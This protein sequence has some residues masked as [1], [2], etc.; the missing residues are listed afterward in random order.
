MKVKIGLEVHVQLNTKTKL[1]CNCPTEQ[2]EPNSSVCE[3]CL[4]M[5]GSKPIANKK[6]IEFAA[7]LA[8]ALNA[9]IQEKNY[10]SRKTYFYPDL[11]KN[12]QI[13]QYETPLAI[14]GCIEL[15]QKKISI[16]RIHLEEDPASLIHEENTAY[17]L[18]DYNRS[19]IP[20]VEIVTE[21]EIENPKQARE[22]L[23]KIT[24]ILNYLE[25]FEEGK[26]ALRADAN[27][28]INGNERAEVK[29]ITSFKAVEKALEYETERQSKLIKEGK[30][31]PRETRGYDEKK[32]ITYSLRAK[33]TE[34]DYGYI[35]DPDLLPITITKQEIEQ[36]QKSLP[37]LPDKKIQRYEK[38]F[39]ITSQQAKTLSSN[40][41]LAKLFEE[42]AKETK[43][44]LTA[45]F[46]AIELIGILNYNESTLSQTKI[47]SKEMIPL[48]KLLEQKKIIPKT[49]EQATIAYITKGISPVKFIQE[50]G[51]LLQLTEKEIEKIIEEFL[52][53]NP[54]TVKDY[55]KGEAKALNYIIGT[56]SRQLKGKADPITIKKI[57]E[58][59]LENY[60]K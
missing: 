10:F 30:K 5:P 47:S 24:T 19:G 57:V 16:R 28:S 44:E 40:P 22:L 7:K 55:L 56:I 8:L 39:K 1:F 41:L 59:T 23:E 50:Q 29:N 6:A 37:E 27:I 52:Q 49:A 2:L 17:S 54:N 14:N 46:L 42:T 20:L 33:E 12:Y 21:P 13:T 3:T 36:I 25:I 26:N 34:E 60:K 45:N 43:P 38:E 32:M 15:E 11:A 31:I 18:A 58:K 35:Y 9:Q 51:M 48:L 4:G 53:T